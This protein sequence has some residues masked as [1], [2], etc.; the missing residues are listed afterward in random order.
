MFALVFSSS[1]DDPWSLPHVCANVLTMLVLDGF[2]KNIRFINENS[3]VLRNVRKQ[4]RLSNVFCDILS[5][6]F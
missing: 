3:R 5:I 4:N 6:N 2:V 1:D